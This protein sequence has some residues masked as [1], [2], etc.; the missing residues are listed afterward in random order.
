MTISEELEKIVGYARDE[1]MRTGN[2]VA[3]EAH[4]F[5]A[6]LRHGKNSAVEALGGA[7]ADLKVLRE[8]IEGPVYKPRS[9]PFSKLDEITFS[10]GAGNV[11]SLAVLEAEKSGTETGAIHLLYAVCTAPGSTVKTALARY[12]ITP[13]YVKG[14]LPEG[15]GELQAEIEAEVQKAA[16]D[17][18]ARAIV[19]S[20]AAGLAASS[21]KGVVS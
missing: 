2:I 14:L 16:Q 19:V 20:G 15:T 3:T 9:I 7:G 18:F 1:A 10:R 6:V 17:A 21:G 13:E 11:L 8:E 4:L 12:G 5:L